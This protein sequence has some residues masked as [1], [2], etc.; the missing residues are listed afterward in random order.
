M[1]RATSA[2]K[3][4]SSLLILRKSDYPQLI[5]CHV[6]LSLPLPVASLSRLATFGSVCKHRR[7]DCI[8]YMATCQDLAPNSKSKMPNSNSICQVLRMLTESFKMNDIRLI[9]MEGMLN[10]RHIGG[11]P[12]VDE[13]RVVYWPHVH[14]RRTSFDL[15]AKALLSGPERATITACHCGWINSLVEP[16]IT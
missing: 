6:S 1:L 9:H 8:L 10:M 5:L 14:R 3:A 11:Y 15:D 13:K 16:D 7:I 4:T 2:S 12:T